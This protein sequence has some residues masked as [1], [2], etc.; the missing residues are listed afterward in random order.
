MKHRRILV[1]LDKHSVGEVLRLRPLASAVKA[2]RAESEV[3]MVV[4]VGA[5]AFFREGFEADRV[6]ASRLA[7]MSNS[8]GMGQRVRKLRELVRLVWRVGLG[9]DDVLA[10]G[11]G[12]T[13][14]DIFG[15][16]VGRRTIGYS[17]RWPGLVDVKVGKYMLEG[18]LVQQTQHTLRAAGIEIDLHDTVDHF[19]S[20]ADDAAITDL[21]AASGLK[22]T[23]PLVALHTGSDWACQQWQ[24]K[25]WSELA[26]RLVQ[27][28]GVN[29]IFTGLPRE[30]EYVEHVRDSMRC[31]STS[32]VGRTTIGQ[33]AALLKRCSLCV[34]VDSAAYDLARLVEVPTVVLASRTMP[35]GPL[36][37][38]NDSQTEINRTPAEIRGTITQCQFKHI[39]GPISFANQCHDYG[40]P[41]AGMRYIPVDEVLQAARVQMA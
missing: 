11:W 20:E 7:E 34:T 27:E 29:I 30:H 25:R 32:L 21:L 4:P 8:R 39:N 1:V 23:A 26:D 10:L 13:L 28:Q 41:F 16:I 15:R 37:S 17:H 3:V 14:L 33:L 19:Y 12:S 31:A 36:R 2:A 5:A 22:D 9:Y 24:P 38:Q 6:V 40:C 35:L 18:D